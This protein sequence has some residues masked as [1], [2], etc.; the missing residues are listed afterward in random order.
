MSRTHLEIIRPDASG[1]ELILGNHGIGGGA[2]AAP[3]YVGPSVSRDCHQYRRPDRTSQRHL[4][5]VARRL[6]Y[7]LQSTRQQCCFFF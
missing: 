4:V 7:R 1:V 5:L 6:L 3:V 2:V